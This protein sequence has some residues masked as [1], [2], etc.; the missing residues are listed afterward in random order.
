M[1]SWWERSYATVTSWSCTVRCLITLNPKEGGMARRNEMTVRCEDTTETPT[2]HMALDL[3]R[4]CWTV[5]FVLPGDRDA[6]LYQIAGGDREALLGLIERQRSRLD[7]AAVRI[8]SCYEAG[9]DAF[10]LDRWLKAHGVDNRIL[11]PASLEVPRRKQR[12]KTDKVDTVGLL[13]VLLRLERGETELTRVV[14]VPDPAVEDA[15][16]RSRER[17]RLVRER[18]AHRNRIRG[19]LA[20]QGVSDIKPGTRGWL[21]RLDA[22]RSGDGRELGPALI[23]EIRREAERLELVERQITAVEAEGRAALDEDTALSAGARRLKRLKGIGEI[24]AGGL[25]HEAFWRDFDNR[26]QVGASFGLVPWPWDSGDVHRDRPISKVGNR[27]ARTLAIECAW[28]WVFHQPA[29]TLS[30]WWRERY[31]G[32]G[33]RLRKIG[34]V[35]VARKLMVALWR[36]LTQ[37][38]VPEGAVVK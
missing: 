3:G 35:A 23:A 32:G 14:R 24:F 33:K 5:G 22:I 38:L 19:L 12:V 27:R 15:R 13:R 20:T 7:E 18:T 17:E 30:R 28:M 37:G 31:A 26:R 10:W 2:I 25:M 34:I 16:R 6:R 36:Y 29:S 4:R 11:D 21:D 1:N 9:R 8:V